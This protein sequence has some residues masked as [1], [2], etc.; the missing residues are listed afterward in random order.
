MAAPAH[1]ETFIDPIP[2]VPTFERAIES[3]IA[4]VERARLRAGDRLP[5]ER[6]LADQLEISRPTLRQALKVLQSTGF[7]TVRRGKGGGIFLRAD[8]VPYDAIRGAVADEEEAVVELLR[9][10]R[11]IEGAVTRE[12]MRNAQPADY[13]DIA[14]TIDLLAAHLGDDRGILRADA[15]FHRAVARAA[16]N[17]ALEGALERLLRDLAGTRTGYQSRPALDARILDVHTR[18][19]AAMRAGDEDALEAVLD[20]H[21]RMVEEE[22][23]ARWGRSWEDVFA[24]TARP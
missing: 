3:I 21:F 10:R 12:A 22:S 19:L 6:D 11:V 8:L 23:A 13:E 1:R 15:M 5:G 24:A 2:P 18:Q 17:R 7:L 20:E 14:R 4:A 16:H 9:A